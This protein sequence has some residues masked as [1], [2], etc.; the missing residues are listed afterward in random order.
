METPKD[1]S[2]RC[3]FEQIPHGK[4]REAKNRLKE[5]IGIKSDA[6]LMFRVNGI[7]QVKLKE[8]WAIEAIFRDYGIEVNWGCKK[9]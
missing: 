9:K 3:A 1:T 8:A 2:F 4:M 7:N 6:G 5:A